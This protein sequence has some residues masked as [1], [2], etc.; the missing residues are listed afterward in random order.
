MLL[1]LTVRAAFLES[2]FVETGPVSE[3]VNKHSSFNVQRN[4]YLPTFYYT[5]PKIITSGKTKIETV[6]IKFQSVGNYCRIYGCL[7]DGTTVH[8]VVLDKSRLVLFSTVVWANWEQ[9]VIVMKATNQVTDIQPKKEVLNFWRQIKD[10]LVLPLLTD[11]SE[12]VGLDHPPCFMQLPTDLKLKIL[13]AVSG[14]D[15]ARVSCVCSKLRCVVSNDELWKHTFFEQFG[16]IG[17]CEN[18]KRTYKQLYASAWKHWGDWT[19][20]L[21]H[22]DPMFDMMLFLM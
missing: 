14:V 13:E 21:T 2:G 6:K 15:L 19:N 11:L 1:E 16:G 3:S 12:K 9:V 18:E 17:T 10:E 5:L 4:W 7:V 20:R 8:S 22:G